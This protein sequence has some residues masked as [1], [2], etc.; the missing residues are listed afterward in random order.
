MNI[1]WEGCKKFR[2]PGPTLDLFLQLQNVNKGPMVESAVPERPL[3]E[4][5][6]TCAH[7]NQVLQMACLLSPLPSSS[8]SPS[9]VVPKHAELK[10]DPS[11][12]PMLSQGKQ[13]SQEPA[14]LL[15]KE[16]Q[17]Q[18]KIPSHPPTSG[19]TWLA[20]IKMVFSVESFSFPRLK[21]GTRKRQIALGRGG[22]P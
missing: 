11:A 22:M 18:L 10:P 6:G 7:L 17:A 20:V 14:F 15:E 3:E 21:T 12:L 5:G 2:I 4:P 16:Q 8:P 13:A 9:W 1:A 19:L